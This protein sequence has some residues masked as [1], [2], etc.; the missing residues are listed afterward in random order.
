MRLAGDEPRV[1]R[2]LNHFHQAV[3]FGA[4]GD[5]EPRV[6]EAFFVKAVYFVAVAVALVND[7]RAVDAGD[8]RAGFE[9]RR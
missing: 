2:Q 9:P 5:D 6:F 1:F 4:A 8:L 3:V 7:L